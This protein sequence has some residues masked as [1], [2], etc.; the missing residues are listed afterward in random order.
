MNP[1]DTVGKEGQNSRLPTF[2]VTHTL[3][4][5]LFDEIEAFCLSGMA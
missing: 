1:D 5:V 2:M 3:G 4:H